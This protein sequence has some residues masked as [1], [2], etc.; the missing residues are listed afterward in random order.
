MTLFMDKPWNMISYSHTRMFLYG[1]TRTT[2]ESWYT[3]EFPKYLPNFVQDFIIFYRKFQNI[4]LTIIQFL[5][6]MFTCL[7][8]F[9]LELFNF[10][11]WNNSNKTEF[12]QIYVPWSCIYPMNYLLFLFILKLFYSH[13]HD[14]LSKRNVR[15]HFSFIIN[16]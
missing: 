7:I 2:R 14:S 11:T 15:K 13:T 12:D 1:F 6:Q 16:N 8:S 5:K 3:Q 10:Y 9:S 4:S